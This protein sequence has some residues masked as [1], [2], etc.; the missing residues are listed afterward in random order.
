VVCV[1]IVK[2]S[3]WAWQS[4]PMTSLRG[5]CNAVTSGAATIRRCDP[6]VVAGIGRTGN[7]AIE[8]PVGLAPLPHRIEDHASGAHLP[9]RADD[10]GRCD[11]ASHSE[12]RAWLRSGCAT[13]LIYR[14]DRLTEKRWPAPRQGRMCT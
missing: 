1:D 9:A 2:Q 12:L 8:L 6:L 13:G 4:L 14:I 3:S 11:F 7:L 10:P 5:T